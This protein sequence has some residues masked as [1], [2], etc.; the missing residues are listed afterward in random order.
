LHTAGLWQWDKRNKTDNCTSTIV[1][2]LKGNG[3][4][5][6]TDR[7]WVVSQVMWYTNYGFCAQHPHQ[8]M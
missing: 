2:V 3:V 4:K 6:A 8:L 1:S 5:N 7:K